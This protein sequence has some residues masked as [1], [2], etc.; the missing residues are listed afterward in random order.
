MYFLVVLWIFEIFQIFYDLG[1]NGYFFVNFVYNEDNGNVEDIE[2][3]WIF[4]E[5]KGISGC[6]FF[7]V[8]FECFVNVF[9]L[10]INL[11][12]RFVLID[13]IIIFDMVILLFR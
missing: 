2:R 3:R 1:E 12:D 7:I 11:I 5:G 10:I 6:L 8:Y 4:D 9:L 13:F